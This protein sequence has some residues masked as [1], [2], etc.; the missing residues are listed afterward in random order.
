MTNHVHL[1]ATPAT[2]HSLAQ[3]MQFLGRLY[4]RHFNY[5]YTRSGTLFEGRFKTCIVQESRYLLTCLRYIELNPIRAGMVKDPSEYHWSSYRAHAFGADARLWS[6]HA[7]F[8]VLGKSAQQR[9]DAWRKLVGETL[10]IEIPAYVIKEFD[11]YL[12]C[13]RL[14]H[15]FLRVRCDSCYDEKL[16]AFSCKKRGFCPSSGARRMANSA[17]LLVDDILPY[18]P[19]RQWV[20]SVPFPLRFLFA[21]NS[22]AMTGVLG[23]VYR[24]VS[25]HLTHK[26]GLS[27]S[28]AQTGAVTLIQCFGGALNLKVHFHM[29]FLDGVYFADELGLHGFVGLKPRTLMSY[30]S[31]RIPSLSVSA[32][33]LSAGVCWSVIP[34][35]PILPRK[36]S[37]P[38]MKT[39]QI[40][41]L[42]VQLT[43]AL[44]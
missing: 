30:P 19:M 1:L 20:L 14:E 34:A 15:G 6:P 36:P 2:N 35:M 23:I 44:L 3:L 41:C 13:G 21:S 28:A 42:E 18:Q 39:H 12:K 37:P 4:V 22:K 8:L 5:T 43:T 32:V 29:L 11:K 26:A 16:V 24:A 27:K 33:T 9:Q 40:I 38:R 31:Q 25:M 7:H 10:D 17:A